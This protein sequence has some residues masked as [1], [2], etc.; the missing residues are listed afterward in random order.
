MG[1]DEGLSFSDYM[2]DSVP[3]D[4]KPSYSLT[5]MQEKDYP[6]Q[7]KDL[8]KGLWEDDMKENVLDRG[9]Q[10]WM[11]PNGKI[12]PSEG[13][14]FRWARQYLAGI[15]HDPN[16]IYAEMKK[17]GFIRMLVIVGE[18]HIEYSG[19]PTATQWKNLIQAVND[20]DLDVL[21]DDTKRRRVEIREAAT[22][23]TS[24]KSIIKDIVTDI[25]M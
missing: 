5:P 3:A 16:D 10:Y 4:V 24:L 15:T 7:A 13:S 20:T 1:L 18:L 9:Q 2:D 11:D 21:Y 25:Y 17:R 19:T 23:I 22:P 8:F 12:I 6:T 14:H